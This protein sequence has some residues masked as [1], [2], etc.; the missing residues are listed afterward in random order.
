[1][2][3]FAAM[4]AIQAKSFL[5]LPLI[6]VVST[7]AQGQAVPQGS[8]VFIAPMQGGLDGFIAP[9]II[10]KKIPLIV[11]TDE[12]QADYVLSGA[13][14]KAD[15][16]WYN[17]VFGGKDKNEGNVRLLDVKSKQMVWAG[18]AGDRSLWAG[19]WKRG[20]ERKVADRIVEQMKKQ[21]FK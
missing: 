12:S 8:K 4:V 10:K 14:L 11:V 16:R 20:G 1:M 9:E 17:T 15:D 6:V 13:S 21:L 2:I 7:I 18:E 3:Y 5:L 19:G